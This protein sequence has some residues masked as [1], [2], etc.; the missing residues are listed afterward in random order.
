MV[1]V[2][3]GILME[4]TDSATDRVFTQLK[5]CMNLPAIVKS[6]IA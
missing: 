5:K 3:N 6:E 4:K 1:Y 2:E